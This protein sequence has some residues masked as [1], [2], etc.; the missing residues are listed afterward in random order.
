MSSEEEA[1]ATGSTRELMTLFWRGHSKEANLQEM[2]LDNEADHLAVTETPEILAML[3]NYKDK[4]VV[5]LGA[6]IGRFTTSLA[7]SSKSVVAVDF[8]Q[9]FVEK[10]RETNGHYGNTTFTCADVTQLDLP[11]SSAD[12]IFSNWLLM[13]LSDEEIVTL[14]RKVLSW[15]RDDGY[16]FFRESCHH[17]SGTKPLVDDFNPT[18]Y[19]SPADYSCL[20]QSVT[21]QADDGEP[22]T[23]KLVYSTNVQTYAKMKHNENQIC[24][25]FKKTRR[26]KDDIHS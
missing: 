5:E 23:F 19:R 17:S 15:L 1:S 6:G 4:D 18:V 20:L 11:S 12:V 7:K 25:L 21:S 26:N 10:N 2:F 16:F 8:I 22:F 9:N 3:P 13:Y 24:W 14:T